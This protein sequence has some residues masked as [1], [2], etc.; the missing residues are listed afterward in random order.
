LRRNVELDDRIGGGVGDEKRFAIGA[1]RERVR[2]GAV[3]LL[4]G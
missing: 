1:E 4:P 2:I 3:I